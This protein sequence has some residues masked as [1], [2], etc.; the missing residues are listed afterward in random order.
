MKKLIIA[1][2]L[3]IAA[4]TGAYAQSSA[5][6]L[7]T[8]DATSPQTTGSIPNARMEVIRNYWQRERPA[9]V[10]LPGG[11]V[12]SRGAVVP[13]GVELRTFP[14]DVGV[15]QYRY[16]VVGNTMYLVSPSDRRV[17]QVVE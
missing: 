8:P 4:S 11:V 3:A 10:V 12:I 9:A 15:A 17:V 14:D 16:I 6:N 7:S 2:A 5:P 13:S 1:S